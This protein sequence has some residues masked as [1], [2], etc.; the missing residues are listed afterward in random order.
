MIFGLRRIAFRP[1]PFPQQFL[2]EGVAV[3]VAFGIA[4]RTGIAI[5]VPGAADAVGRFEH[6]HR[7]PEPIAQAMQL[8][9]AGEPGAD[10]QGVERLWPCSTCPTA[11][12]CARLCHPIF[13][14]RLRFSRVGTR[15]RFL[16]R[17]QSARSGYLCRQGRCAAS[18]ALERTG[19]NGARSL[20][21]RWASALATAGRPPHGPW[22][23]LAGLAPTAYR[24]RAMPLVFIPLGQA[25]ELVLLQEDEIDAAARAL[26]AARAAWSR[27]PVGTACRR[28]CLRA[29]RAQ[30]SG[31]PW[32]QGSR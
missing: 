32:W 12:C 22:R 10:D 28:R 18:G 19:A 2:R 14:Y 5:P 9:E 30:A 20:P 26:V 24:R 27:R 6:L 23:M 3:G 8:V 31:L 11:R 21:G 4:A 13:R 17:A 25:A 16:H 1:I 15:P 7:K 29:A